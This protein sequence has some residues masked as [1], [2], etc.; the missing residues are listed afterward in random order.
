MK[1]PTFALCFLAIWA[2]A[3]PGPAAANQ[4]TPNQDRLQ[5]QSDRQTAPP[6]RKNVQISAPLP[7][8]GDMSTQPLGAQAFDAFQNGF[9]SAFGSFPTHNP[10]VPSFSVDPMISSGSISTMNPA[11]RGAY[12]LGSMQTLHS[13][14]SQGMTF[15]PIIRNQNSIT[16]LSDDNLPYGGISLSSGIFP[17]MRPK[18]RCRVIQQQAVQVANNLVKRQNKVIFKELMDY[19]LKSKFLI[20]MTEV[21]LNRVLRRKFVALMKRYSTL[22]DDNVRLISSEDD[23]IIDSELEDEED[24][25]DDHGSFPSL[26]H[27][28]DGWGDRD[29]DGGFEDVDEDDNIPTIVPDPHSLPSMHDPATDVPDSTAPD[30]NSSPSDHSAPPEKKSWL[31]RLFN[32]KQKRRALKEAQA[33]AGAHPTQGRGPS[34]A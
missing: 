17:K 23:E 31:Q 9:P 22:S 25:V 27:S 3:N 24:Q 20:G 7:F 16:R 1:I 2:A 6:S 34:K 21:K 32:W 15:A 30:A 14:Q 33:E 13:L 12:P 18:D 4:P 29:R 19:I 5:S 8:T 11:S 10:S 28:V 26:G